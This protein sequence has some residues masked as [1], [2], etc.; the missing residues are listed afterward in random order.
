MPF[1]S[2]HRITSSTVPTAASA[3]VPGLS[4]ASDANP[5][6]PPNLTTSKCCT[7]SSAPYLCSTAL[8]RSR[9][10]PGIIAA[11]R[12]VTDLSLFSACRVVWFHAYS[13]SGMPNATSSD[14]EGSKHT[15]PSLSLAS[16]RAGPNDGLAICASTT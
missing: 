5:I 14:R 9:A 12:Y 10:S 1:D 3:S 7:S 13:Y 16:L 2:C 15:S 11:C 8:T 4:S 6:L